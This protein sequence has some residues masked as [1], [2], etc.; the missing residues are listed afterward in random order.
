MSRPLTLTDHGTL[1]LR[2]ADVVMACIDLLRLEGWRCHRLQ[3]GTVK[4]LDGAR[5]IRLEDEGTP[6]WIAVSPDQPAVY[7]EFKRPAAKPNF[8]QAAMH[9]AMRRDGFR[10]LVIDSVEKLRALLS[11]NNAA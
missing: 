9:H 1:R 7:I 8:K 11:G 4:T 2:E 6:D 5:H 10:V 3:A